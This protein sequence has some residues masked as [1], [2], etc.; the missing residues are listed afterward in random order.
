MNNKLINSIYYNFLIL[1]FIEQ[2]K[3]TIYYNEILN[4]EFSNLSSNL[5][6]NLITLNLKNYLKNTTILTRN[7]IGGYMS[8]INNNI[9]HS[10]IMKQVILNI[11]KNDNNNN[12]NFKLPEL[13]KTLELITSFSPTLKNKEILFEIGFKIFEIKLIKFKE[14]KY[15][16]DEEI[17]SKL[18]E[19]LNLL[20][21]ID[22]LS[23]K[24]SNI[25][26]PIIIKFFNKFLINYQN[27]NPNND[28]LKLKETNYLNYLL[29]KNFDLICT[30]PIELSI[31]NP[32][33]YKSRIYLNNQRFLQRISINFFK[34]PN[35]IINFI[36]NK[37]IEWICKD[38]NDWINKFHIKLFTFGIFIEVLFRRGSRSFNENNFSNLND[39]EFLKSI[40]EEMNKLSKNELSWEIIERLSGFKWDK[41][42]KDLFLNDEEEGDDEI[43]SSIIMV[44]NKIEEENN[45]LFNERFQMIEKFNCSSD[46]NNIESF[47]NLT[48]S[49]FESNIEFPI[50]ENDEDLLNLSSNDDNY[51]NKKYSKSLLDQDK[52]EFNELYK[53]LKNYR[54]FLPINKE[55]RNDNN[56]ND[57]NFKK[58]YTTLQKE[59]LVRLYA[60]LRFK[61]MLIESL[62]ER[63]PI[64]I[65]KL[66]NRLYFEYNDRIPIIL[67]HSAMI[68]L[69][70]SKNNEKIK[71]NEKI[72]LIKILDKIITIIYSTSS[73]KVYSY[74]FMN[75]VKFKQFRIN[76][77]DLIINESKI[78]NSG[79]IKTLNW[80]IN[81]ISYSPN[82][83][84]YKNSFERWNNELN[85]MKDSKIGFWNPENKGKWIWND[86]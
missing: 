44:L 57:K 80:A 69:I 70:K 59:R 39:K 2:L 72:N 11:F 67:I 55:Q 76:L 56:D 1:K 35:E 29:N 24:Y 6:I 7:L 61:S 49:L 15:F 77:V 27:L 58:K 60:P 30:T 43:G 86:K 75:C 64:L 71:F 62:I 41:N 36:L 12:N 14:F 84:E 78:T 54:Q 26:L 3:F 33:N 25:F 65:D 21:S 22:S 79:S 66:I 53:N 23:F 31:L 85:N 42:S 47:D 68:G 28:I 83:K 8:K 81:K 40:N 45:L 5:K 18:I 46:I 63:N 74:L 38:N 10:F 9:E 13:L 37:R 19:F 32:K 50:N 52:L 73:K 34:L 4:I 82:M 17:Y 51:D 16:K 20:N 48:D